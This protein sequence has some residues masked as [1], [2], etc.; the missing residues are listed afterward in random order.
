LRDKF[1]KS[2]GF[3]VGEL[4]KG[5]QETQM[6]YLVQELAHSGRK[7]VVIIWTY[8]ERVK[9]YLS[10][11]EGA[12]VP[13]LKLNKE[14]IFKKVLI[15]RNFLKGQ[16][17]G[18]LQSFAYYLNA[19]AWILCLFTSRIPIGA[20]R[21]RLKQ[22]RQKI[23]FLKFWINAILPRRK[24]SNNHLYQQDMQFPAISL[25]FSKTV[26]ITNHLD[27]EKFNTDFPV[28][29]AG[30]EFR[31]ASMARLYPEKSIDV[32]IHAIRIIVDSGVKL[33]HFHAGSGPLLDPLTSLVEKLDLQSIFYFVDEKLDIN[34]FLTDKH[35][36]LH[37]STYE[38]YPNV[39][40]EAM[41]CAK[42]IVTTDCGDVSYL[43][44]EGKNGH[45]VAVGDYQ[46]LAIKTIE[47][48]SDNKRMKSFSEY[49]RQSAEKMFNL[50]HF[51]EVILERYQS[52]GINTE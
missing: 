13:V 47:L 16:N 46:S 14:S 4:G 20:I 29:Q 11:L 23:S 24:I 50:E 28:I 48:L 22:I 9:Y 37:S 19:V 10:A 5:G 7:C 8:E 30:A 17:A 49:S 51:K 3:I 1:T 52:Y 40:M 15:S 39:I 21:N 2:L 43:V 31:T 27:V 6:T 25:A 36:I 12:G 41:A 44:E 42:P 18:S 45:I 38:G 35:L 32:L 34:E 26:I 33:K